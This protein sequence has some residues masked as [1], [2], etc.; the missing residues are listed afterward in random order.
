[1]AFQDLSEYVNV[2]FDRLDKFIP[3]TVKQKQY[4]QI[5]YNHYNKLFKASNDLAILLWD[6]RLQKALKEVFTSASFYIESL[7][8]MQNNY[9]N[10]Y[11]YLSYYSLFHAILS[12]LYLEPSLQIKDVFQ[13]GHEKAINQFCSFYC[14]G[15]KQIMSDEIQK[16]F[17][18]L[19][20][21]REYYSYSMPFNEFFSEIE[22]LKRPDDFLRERLMHC[23]QI[24]SLLSNIM[25]KASRKYNDGI[26]NI[27]SGNYK[28]FNEWFDK[29]SGKPNPLNEKEYLLNFSDKLFK[30][31]FLS[32]RG[33]QIWCFAIHLE[34][35]HDEFNTYSSPYRNPELAVKTIRFVY[36]ALS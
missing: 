22:G 28:D 19:R 8:C 3:D 31:H 36:E 2:N 21:Y 35:F 10:S 32:G 25:E 24:A 30:G 17:S 33:G 15:K 11:F 16:E 14:K 26:G 5:Q 7:F 13:I 9:L 34:H 12:V 20:Y 18:L 6:I 23:F 4:Y 27:T 29:I 1:M